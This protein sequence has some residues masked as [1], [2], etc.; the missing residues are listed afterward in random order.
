MAVTVTNQR[1][2][3]HIDALSGASKHPLPVEPHGRTEQRF[4][5]AICY[6][7]M[8][9]PMITPCRPV[10]HTFC[11]ECIMKALAIKMTCPTCREPIAADANLKELSDVGKQVMFFQCLSFSQCQ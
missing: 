6:E 9:S 2:R 4:M 5:C 3:R 10:C 7:F 8:I 1:K 11:N